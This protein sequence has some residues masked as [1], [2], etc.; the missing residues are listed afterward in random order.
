MRNLQ[1]SGFPI[2]RVIATSASTEA[3]NPKAAAINDLSPA[4]FVDDNLP[5][6][7]GIRS[8]IH[9]ALVHRQRNRSP[10]EGP[11]LVHAKSQH[12]SLADFAYWWLTSKG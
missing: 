1:D 12:V 9:T 4:A 8:D 6:L 3:G 11:D 5:Y 2:E 7:R 10:N